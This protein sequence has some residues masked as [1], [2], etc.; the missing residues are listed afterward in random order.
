MRKPLPYDDPR[1]VQRALRARP[2]QSGIIVP[3][4]GVR[5]ANVR[6]V[7]PECGGK[8]NPLRMPSCKEC[9]GEGE[10]TNAELSAYEARELERARE[11]ERRHGTR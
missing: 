8:F 7:C 5:D 9:H 6:H 10:M 2:G 3:G 11:E 4:A 1:A